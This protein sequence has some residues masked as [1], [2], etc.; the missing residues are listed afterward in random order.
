M[1]HRQI[2]I[3]QS[4][5]PALSI[6]GTPIPH[7]EYCSAIPIIR[8]SAINP[9]HFWHS[10]SLK[11]TRLP[12]EQEQEEYL[13]QL[14]ARVLEGI[15][16]IQGVQVNANCDGRMGLQ[17]ELRRALISGKGSSSASS[18]QLEAHLRSLDQPAAMVGNKGA[19]AGYSNATKGTPRAV[20]PLVDDSKAFNLQ[21]GY[22][23]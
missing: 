6:Y 15:K 22:I 16:C 14:V 12:E 19:A 9:G 3:G 23:S 4:P 8:T 20:L 7:F 13:L 10:L 17:E 1:P 21:R 2:S 11:K 18:E 5:H